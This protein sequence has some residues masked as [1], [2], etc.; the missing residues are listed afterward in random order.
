MN[1]STQ[2]TALRSTLGS[3]EGEAKARIQA[4]LQLVLLALAATSVMPAGGRAQEEAPSAVRAIPGITAEDPFP[5]ACVSCHVVLPDGRDVRVSTMM[6]RW[7]ETV[8]PPLLA[9]ARASV[10]PGTRLA[11]V[12][13]E[14]ASALADIPGGCLSCHRDPSSPAPPFSRLMHQVHLTGGEESTFL[15]MFQGEC[16]YCHKLDATTGAWSIPSGPEP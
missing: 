10:G 3:R 14:V 9:H 5:G 12:H 11:G 16:T 2:D 4:G 15:T 6:T 7:T 1:T 13:P 8:D